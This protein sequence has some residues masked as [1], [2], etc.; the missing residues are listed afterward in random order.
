MAT[1]PKTAGA[2]VVLETSFPIFIRLMAISSE[3]G[4]PSRFFGCWDW[5]AMVKRK[6]CA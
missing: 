5:D 2:G 3:R 6:E 4:M 1:E